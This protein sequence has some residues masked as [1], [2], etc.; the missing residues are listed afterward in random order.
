MLAEA[1]QV[2]DD[3]AASVAER[4]KVDRL[5]RRLWKR[6]VRIEK[7]LATIGKDR[8]ALAALRC[9]ASAYPSTTAFAQAGVYGRPDGVL[10]FIRRGGAVLLDG[11]PLRRLST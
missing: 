2:N 11:S 5:R 9:C 7:L 1:E 3:E 4:D 10:D 6:F 8:A